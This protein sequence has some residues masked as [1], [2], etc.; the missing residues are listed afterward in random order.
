MF[1][2]SFN[3]SNKLINNLSTI[4]RLYGQLEGMF[5]PKNLLLNL[6]TQNLIES[7]Y[8]SNSIEGNPLTQNEVTNLLLDDRVPVNRDEKEVKNYFEILKN[9]GSYTDN[10]LN[11]D[12][13][14]KIHLDLMKGVND[15]IAGK[16]RNK[17]IVIGKYLDDKNENVSLQVKHEPPSH[18][19]SEIESSLIFLFDWL[20]KS[21]R[22]SI[23]KAG[24]FHHQFVFIHPFL[25]G[26]GRTCRLLTAL[27]LLNYGYKVNKYFV[28]D[29]YYDIDREQYS[30]KLHTADYKDKTEWLE[31]FTDG[32]KY[33]LQSS[34]SKTKDGVSNLRVNN[35]PT[36]KEGEVLDIIK[37]KREITSTDL[38]KILDVSRQQAHQLLSALVEKKF[39]EK[40]G[41]T[42]SSYYVLV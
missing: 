27:I 25:D 33:S 6:K 10:S 7:S 35:R 18:N 40:K 30:D 20:K 36:D 22:Q 42:K 23:L 9:L 14:L 32:I 3:L 37:E 19:K 29:D 38:A 11:L 16:I 1:E 17:V 12:V 15:E 5:I 41:K 28:L 8:V 4:E 13:A 21:D 34:L 26:N 31:Y 2:P 24:I 39:L